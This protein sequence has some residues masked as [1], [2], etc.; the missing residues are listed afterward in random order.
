MLYLN[1][2]NT[3]QPRVR[4]VVKQEFQQVRRTKW[5]KDS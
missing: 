5:T 4:L 3:E 2:K 1:I